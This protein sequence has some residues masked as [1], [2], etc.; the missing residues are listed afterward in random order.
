MSK[1]AVLY[2]RV[3]SEQQVEDGVSLDAQEARLRAYC[4]G[5]G[6]EAVDVLREQGELNAAGVGRGV[7]AS[8]IPL[9]ERPQGKRLL[10]MLA[11]GEVG[12]VVAFKLDRLFRD[13]VDCLTIT[14]TWDKS[15]VSL[16][17]VD[18]GGQSLNTGSAMG[19]MFLTMCAGFA[20]L[21]AGLISERTKMALGHLKAQGVKLGAPALGETPEEAETLRYIRTLRES[22][23]RLQAIADR[24]NAEGRPTKRGGAWYAKTVSNCLRM[25]A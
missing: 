10:V 1:R 9:C 3:S 23:L 11:A 4:I 20:E 8:N 17:L 16:H 13:T 2:I 15:D 12:H 14:R 19:R 7:S 6:L 21:E 5:A 18:M 22:G 24:L 25:A